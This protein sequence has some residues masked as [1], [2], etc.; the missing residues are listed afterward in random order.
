MTYCKE[1]LSRQRKINELEEEINSLKG[2]LRY[3]ERTAKEG[4]FG[5]STPSSKLP[6]K[7]NSS[8]EKQSNSGGAKVGHKG[9]GRASIC[10]EHA[11]KVE[12]IGLDNTCPDCG[13]ALEHKGSKNRTVVDCRPVKMKKIVYRLQRKRCCKCKRVITARPPGVL[14]KCLYGNQLLAYVAVQHYI[15]G[16]TLGQIEKQTGIGYSSL[17]EAMHQL[18]RRLK[19]VP[20]S[21]IFS[22]RQAAVKHAD[23]TGWR[24]DGRSGYSWLF[25][26]DDISIFRFRKSR[27]ARIASEVF[28][29]KPVPG[30]LVVDRYNGYNKMPCLI[31]YC[32]A[33]LLRAV[34][35]LEKDF[36][37]NAE[38]KSFVGALTAQLANAISLRTLE[39]TDKQSKRQAAKIKATIIKIT[40]SQAK[41]P[42]IQKI[43]DI[44]REKAERLYHWADDRNVPADN[45]RAERELRPLV[46][47]RKISFGSQSNAGARTR[48]VLMTVLH[49]LKKR[50]SDVTIA[51]KSALDKLAAQPNVDPYEA[52]FSLDSS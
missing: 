52:I 37:E 34:K 45:N 24:T 13:G 17:I 47:A 49:T 33:H 48:E 15:Y 21:L 6:V 42:A 50:T 4:F 18:A 27:S 30:V 40:N 23:E 10:E 43:Q 38:I 39:I 16:N 35:D 5:S 25:C 1:C 19:N 12:T 31:Q 14:A 7:A 8:K 46:I 20:E 22:Y 28:G 9:H 41:H 44:F 32:Y 36:P 3:Q 51:F 2:K 11:D 26:T 29:E